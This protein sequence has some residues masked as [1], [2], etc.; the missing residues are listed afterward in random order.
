MSG[1]WGRKKAQRLRRKSLGN[2]SAHRSVQVNTVLEPRAM[3]E[4]VIDAEVI[5]SSIVTCHSCGTKN[6]INRADSRGRYRCGSCRAVIRDPFR[7]PFFR[8]PHLPY[9]FRWLVRRHIRWVFV[10]A[11]GLLVIYGVWQDHAE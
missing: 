7:R 11:V 2:P 1:I 6:R 4:K 8:W 5:V 9:S 10:G 3:S